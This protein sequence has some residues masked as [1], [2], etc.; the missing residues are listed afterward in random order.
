MIEV[1][2]Q[3]PVTVCVLD[4][5]YESLDTAQVDEFNACLCNAVDQAE[6]PLFVIDL[7]Q[8]N[9]IG[10]SFLEVLF[11]VWK[12]LQDRSGR[13]ALCGLSEFCQEVLHSTRLDTL[14]PSFSTRQAAIQAM[15]AMPGS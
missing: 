6:H 4:R 7:S 5:T 8:T 9:F 14:W 1:T 10:S 13:M 3:D 11:R 15:S 2:L 12:R